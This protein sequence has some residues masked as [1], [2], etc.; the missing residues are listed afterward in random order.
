MNQETR[1]CTFI[2]KI[3]EPLFYEAIDEWA[4]E[5]P[6]A[7]NDLAKTNLMHIAK[8]YNQKVEERGEKYLKERDEHE[9][10]N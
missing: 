8:I 3:W 5:N 2:E 1:K 4:K 6:A 9:R 10:N 7:K